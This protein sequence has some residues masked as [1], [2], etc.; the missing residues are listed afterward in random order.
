ML[1]A[2]GAWAVLVACASIVACSDSQPSPGAGS[3]G[4]AGDTGQGAAGQGEAGSTS[5]LHPEQVETFT[6]AP[7]KCGLSRRITPLHTD[8]SPDVFVR[9]GSAFSVSARDALTGPSWLSV[10][11]DGA[12]QRLC[13]FPWL[14]TER[15]LAA[16]PFSTAFASFEPV[17]VTTVTESQTRLH[18][19]SLDANGSSPQ[20]VGAYFFRGTTAIATADSFDGRRSLF[21]ASHPSALTPHAVL[22]DSTGSR[23]GDE[24][25]LDQDLVDCMVATSTAHSAAL[26]FVDRTLSPEV[27]RVF[28]LDAAGSIV[29]QFEL[30]YE[31]TRC[32]LLQSSES[33]LLAAVPLENGVQ[34]YA[35]E[36]EATPLWAAPRDLGPNPPLWLHRAEDG[37]VSLLLFNSGALELVKVEPSGTQTV[38]ASGLPVGNVIPSPAGELFMH[39]LNLDVSNPRVDTI[40]EI[41]CNP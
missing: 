27:F 38:L 15:V 39:G 16:L 31:S 5:D 23:L 13:S 17:L 4:A 28:E 40:D 14:G 34:V 2:V 9:Q 1:G 18:T 35:L 6:V 20:D 3:G 8:F 7:G 29:R 41:T 22:L 21:A 33:G 36:Q 24:I 12:S 37:S 11:A 26:S 32:P 30:P 10:S 19:W 25:A